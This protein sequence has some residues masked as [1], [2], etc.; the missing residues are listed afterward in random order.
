MLYSLLYNLTEKTQG[1]GDE[2]TDVCVPFKSSGYRDKTLA[3]HVCADRE[4]AASKNIHYTSTFLT[5]AKV[6]M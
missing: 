4:D 5:R 6:G 3:W 2:S 1:P